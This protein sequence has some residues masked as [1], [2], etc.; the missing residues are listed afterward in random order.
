MRVTF[1]PDFCGLKR[2]SVSA[3]N[4]DANPFSASSSVEPTSKVCLSPCPHLQRS[5]PHLKS[6]GQGGKATRSDLANWW[7]AVW[8]RLTLTDR[9]RL[10]LVISAPLK[11]SSVS[12]ELATAGL[13]ELGLWPFE[14]KPIAGMLWKQG[15][16][17]VGFTAQGTRRQSR[18]NNTPESEEQNEFHLSSVVTPS[19][20]QSGRT[21]KQGSL[22]PK[23]P[24]DVT[25]SPVGVLLVPCGS[26]GSGSLSNRLRHAKVA[27][28]CILAG[29]V[30]HDLFRL[31]SARKIEE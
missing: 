18:R 13:N 27:A 19:N 30:D 23:F 3:R 26:G 6:I 15:P 17:T 11:A 28:D 9:D 14:K 8:C 25:S 21:Q 29:L 20:T 2:E 31:V 5:V 10:N 12:V 16:H 7:T 22:T 24:R 1:Q 4:T